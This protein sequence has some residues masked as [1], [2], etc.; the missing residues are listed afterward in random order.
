MDAQTKLSEEYKK[1]AYILETKNESRS[2]RSKRANE[3][4]KGA[5]LSFS[6]FNIT[7]HFMS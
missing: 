3:S 5:N 2:S 7:E 4:L 1:H 6:V